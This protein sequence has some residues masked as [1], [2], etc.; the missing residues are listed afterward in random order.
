[1]RGPVH[2]KLLKLVNDDLLGV[3]GFEDGEVFPAEERI[4]L[5]DRLTQ[6]VFIPQHIDLVVEVLIV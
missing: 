2:L 3:D 1:M 5:E 4:Q 6:H